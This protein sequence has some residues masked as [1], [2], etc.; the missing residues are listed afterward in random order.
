MGSSRVSEMAM[1]IVVVLVLSQLL[2]AN[3]EEQPQQCSFSRKPPCPPTPTG[4]GHIVLVHGAGQGQWFWYKVKPIL[5]AAGYY[6]TTVQLGPSVT[7]AVDSIANVTFSNYSQPL[8][9]LMECLDHK[10]LLVAH[11][12]GGFNI[13]VAMDKYPNKILA[14]VF[15]AAYMPDTAHPMSYVLD[16][17]ANYPTGGGWLDT[18][19]MTIGNTTWYFFGDDFLGTKLY[20]M[21]PPEDIALMHTQKRSGSFF[22]NEMAEMQLTE[23]NYGSVDRF[24][25]VTGDD[26]TIA[27]AFQYVM[28]ENFPVKEQKLIN[29]SGHEV[30]LSKPLE[31]S[32]NILDIARKYY[33]SF[34]TPKAAGDGTWDGWVEMRAKP[35]SLLRGA[36]W[37]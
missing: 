30:M 28:I 32:A 17:G 21:C 5:E 31:L 11:S 19:V 35:N 10:V 29:S 34:V 25:I 26:L 4:L 37:V 9:D 16:Q 3:G 15:I 6:V 18:C 23:E 33:S 2:L 8:F 1:S 27:T 36:L 24:Y 20:Q 12:A 7:M 13:A 14:A 22:Y